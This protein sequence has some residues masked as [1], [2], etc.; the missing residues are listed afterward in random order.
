MLS[1][2]ARFEPNINRDDCTWWRLERYVYGFLPTHSKNVYVVTGTLYDLEASEDEEI[3][4]DRIGVPTH[5]Y[6]VIVH[7]SERGA[8]MMEAFVVPNSDEVDEYED[9]E[10]FRVDIDDYLP[11]I[12]RDTVL[13]FFDKLERSVIRKPVRPYINT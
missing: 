6:K 9:L 13:R 1:N 5:Y 3:G 11:D 2:I 8:L 7:E 12:E 10:E 4:V